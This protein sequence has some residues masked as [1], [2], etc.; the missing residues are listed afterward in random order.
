MSGFRFRGIVINF[1]IGCRFP[2]TD[3]VVFHHCIKIR[4]KYH[5]TIHLFLLDL[6]PYLR[7][8]LSVRLL[9]VHPQFPHLFS[10]GIRHVHH[11]SLR[12][13]S[14][15]RKHGLHHDT[16]QKAVHH[17]D[18]N[19]GKQQCGDHQSSVSEK[20][21][22]LFFHYCDRII[23]HGPFPPHLPLHRS[24]KNDPP[25]SSLHRVSADFHKPSSAH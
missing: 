16:A 12:H 11:I 15:F 21:G 5:Q 17:I 10:Y 19:S 7:Q 25:D 22:Q 1:Y 4:R 3:L 13:I 14:I 6:L 2:T 8:L 23:C 24:Q 18:H 20:S 9:P